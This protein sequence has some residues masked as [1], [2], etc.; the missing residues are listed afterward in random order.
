MTS[1]EEQHFGF[2]GPLIGRAKK[3]LFPEQADI[4]SS[5][6]SVKK[7][8]GD[9]KRNKSRAKRAQNTG[10]SSV[11]VAATFNVNSGGMERGASLQ[12]LL[13]ENE[14]PIV[15]RRCTVQKMDSLA[16]MF[17]VDEDSKPRTIQRSVAGNGSKSGVGSSL[18]ERSRSNDCNKHQRHE[19]NVFLQRQM[20][21][22]P[23]RGRE[24]KKSYQR[25]DSIQYSLDKLSSEIQMVVKSERESEKS[26]SNQ[27]S[28]KTDVKNECA[29]NSKKDRNRRRGRKNNAISALVQE[30]S[31]SKAGPNKRNYGV[32]S[33]MTLPSSTI[34]S[35]PQN[36]N[37]ASRRHQSRKPRSANNCET[38]QL[39]GNPSLNDG[40]NL[41][42]LTRDVEGLA[43]RDEKKN[44]EPSISDLGT[45]HFD[46]LHSTMQTDQRP[47]FNSPPSPPSS[48]SRYEEVSIA[49]NEQNTVSF[50]SP[51]K[52]PSFRSPFAVRHSH[53]NCFISPPSFVH[54]LSNLTN[55]N[56]FQQAYSP[57]ADVKPLKRLDKKKTPAKLTPAS[58]LVTEFCISPPIARRNRRGNN[59][60]D[61]ISDALKT[62]CTPLV[63]RQQ[64]GNALAEMVNMGKSFDCDN[65]G[66]PPA[67][68]ITTMSG[69]KLFDDVMELDPTSN[70]NIIGRED[71]QQA[72]SEDGPKNDTECRH[73]PGSAVLEVEQVNQNKPTAMSAALGSV[74]FEVE[75]AIPIDK[76]MTKPQKVD[77]N[78]SDT[79]SDKSRNTIQNKSNRKVG[80]QE[81]QPLA[82][83]NT[84]NDNA[85]KPSSNEKVG[86]S[87]KQPPQKMMDRPKEQPSKSDCT[88]NIENEPVKTQLR[89]SGRESKKT[90][91]LT[92][93][94]NDRCTTNHRTTKP[95]TRKTIES[96]RTQQV[97]VVLDDELSK[98]K[99][100]QCDGASYVDESDNLDVSIN[101]SLQ[102]TSDKLLTVTED[103]VEEK[104]G[105][106]CE[107]EKLT[108]ADDGIKSES[109]VA[110]DHI[111]RFSSSQWSN[112]E[113]SSLRRAQNSVN[114]ISAMFWEDVADLVAGR[115]SKECRDKWFSLTG[116]PSVRS[117]LQSRKT[118]SN[119]VNDVSSDDDEDDLFN[120]TPFRTTYANTQNGNLA[121]K[122][123]EGG[124]DLS[125]GLS[126]CTRQ[127]S[128]LDSQ[129]ADASARKQRTGYTTYINNLRRDLSALEKLPK[130]SFEH[131]PSTRRE[132]VIRIN[133][134]NGSGQLLEDGTVKIS[135][136]EDESEED[137]IYG[138]GDDG[139]L[140][141]EDED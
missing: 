125:F 68:E 93:T 109:L 50:A 4:T 39:T 135:M 100:V 108:P 137:D 138:G 65:A 33:L 84:A 58:P 120:S 128:T 132:D 139:S 86:L 64:T 116:T 140:L 17:E 114:P 76:L 83:D 37:P 106:T 6:I 141:D 21:Q 12:Q 34:K 75:E 82:S 130:K 55:T 124:F 103:C 136:E 97:S 119:T 41:A 85:T 80:R 131:Q 134:K 31:F 53:P 122:L 126:P 5:K 27:Q 92:V 89:R 133:S 7:S 3:C 15:N 59:S 69:S 94:W 57:F 45:H 112:E 48:P 81:K 47:I 74:V 123:R 63:Q 19:T 46:Q 70:D 22:I 90:D 8:N 121:Q 61:H 87:R 127:H 40:D 67:T 117:K 77:P 91:R 101:N 105:S 44:S 52:S 88:R 95:A 107:Q 23:S 71:N 113:I 115:T 25:N 96:K 11:L 20:Q 2:V 99:N 29:D 66:R 49:S 129:P 111:E 1:N 118:I 102:E 35:N 24:G 72:Y 42:S 51:L 38:I 36:F 104:R 60:V 30:Q 56:I 13:K 18:G 54:R 78:S 98:N 26:K 32:S 110:V 16:G 62:I 9:G 73:K 79:V 43:L 28:G 14:A 10:N